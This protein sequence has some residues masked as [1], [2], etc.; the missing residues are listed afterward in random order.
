MNYLI[1]T[2]TLLIAINVQNYTQFETWF[3]F[4]AALQTTRVQM[5]PGTLRCTAEDTSATPAV[6][7]SKLS[8]TLNVN[9]SLCVASLVPVVVP[10]KE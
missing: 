10:D 8:W 5:T 3:A 1:F 4:A 2:F 9:Q 7:R 6:P